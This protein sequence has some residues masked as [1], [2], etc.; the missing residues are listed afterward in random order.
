MD[1]FFI[2]NYKYCPNF[3][4]F[5]LILDFY[6][7]PYENHEVNDYESLKNTVYSLFD[8]P[9]R[10][11]VI[12]NFYSSIVLYKTWLMDNT[13]SLILQILWWKKIPLDLKLTEILNHETWINNHMVSEFYWLSVGNNIV[14]IFRK[15]FL[16]SERNQVGNNILIQKF[17]L[18]NGLFQ[19]NPWFSGMKIGLAD[20]S[21]LILIKTIVQK[22]SN[23]M[24][25]YPHL[26]NWYLRMNNR[27]DWLF[28]LKN[29]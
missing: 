18:L 13:V 17:Q 19:D 29:Q 4:R 7:I 16:T 24:I 5:K 28:F 27:Q 25:N 8:G 20:F 9:Q 11:Q 6:E 21:L 15:P 1:K 23:I 10:N 2:I 22:N 26:Q 14:D 12:N 3:T